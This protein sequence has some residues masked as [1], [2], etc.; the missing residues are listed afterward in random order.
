MP[1]DVYAGTLSQ[2]VSRL[3]NLLTSM[4]SSPFT[5]AAQWSGGTYPWYALQY[6][7]P[8]G[9]TNNNVYIIIGPTAFRTTTR[10][11]SGAS[12]DSWN[13]CNTTTYAY[14]RPGNIYGIF[15]GIATSF[16]TTN[17]AVPSTASMYATFG[18]R[19]YDLTVTYNVGA[20]AC[21]DT[22]IPYR[23]VD[24][25]S[26]FYTWYD[27]Y[28]FT[29]IQ[30]PTRTTYRDV[31]FTMHA[32]RLTPFN[33]NI[34]QPWWTLFTDQTALSTVADTYSPY[35]S[36]Y[37]KFPTYPTNLCGALT[38]TTTASGYGIC[39]DSPTSLNM[40]VGIASYLT[41][42]NVYVHTFASSLR[43]MTRPCPAAL[44]DGPRGP[45]SYYMQV[46]RFLDP[47]SNF[48]TWLPYGEIV[49][50]PTALSS[51]DGKVYAFQPIVNVAHGAHPWSLTGIF[52]PITTLLPLS[53]VDSGISPGDVLS[54]QGNQYVAVQY[55][56]IM[57]GYNYDV[58][59]G[60]GNNNTV[61]SDYTFYA[62]RYA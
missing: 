49:Y 13:Y 10:T 29:F 56:N 37:T 62:I 15:V 11:A 40:P 23:Y 22:T 36:I 41:G 52:A 26:T 57:T 14:G 32:Y 3:V 4:T 60:G 61:N 19:A 30:I 9:Y 31:P 28:G 55:S 12:Y 59:L 33:T 5:L 21:N 24:L 38:Y 51:V 35:G 6:N 46:R 58:C 2:Y 45:M 47:S 48:C 25:Q 43:Q 27:Q 39:M 1:F 8:N 20:T 50:L 34:T 53:Y 16:D 54:I 44:S 7:D 42:S 18:I 17:F